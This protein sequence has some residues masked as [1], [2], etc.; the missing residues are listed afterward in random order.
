MKPSQVLIVGDLSE[1]AEYTQGLL[2]SCSIH[3]TVVTS[4]SEALKRLRGQDFGAMVFYLNGQP[5]ECR[6][7]LAVL[8]REALYIPVVVV[9]E[10]TE[11]PVLAE[12]GAAGAFDFLVKPLD[13]TSF[14]AVMQR[15]LTRSQLCAGTSLAPGKPKRIPD[16]PFADQII[17]DSEAMQEVYHGVGKVAQSD[18][19]VCLYGESGT[20][21]ELI[22]RA[23]HD[24]GRRR[25]RP[26]VVL[27]CAAIPEGLMESEM[28]G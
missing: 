11:R 9:A 17:G 24:S 10:A 8:Q 22:A 15:A 27:D 3:S 25:G 4:R 12:W 16:W 26:F 7:L 6:E 5:G 2:S 1:D 21:K 19:N 20:G 18:A 23:I 14:F 13:H 28:F